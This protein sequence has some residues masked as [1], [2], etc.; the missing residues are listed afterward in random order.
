MA[1][2]CLLK[3]RIIVTTVRKAV[4]L[5][6]GIHAHN[7]AGVAVG[8]TITAVHNGATHVQGTINGY[9]ERTGNADLVVII[10]NLM[11][12]LKKKCIP[13]ASLKRL[14]EFSR[15]VDELANQT[16]NSRQPYVGR[17]SFAHK[18][19]IHVSAM[20]RHQATYE[21]IPPES[22]GNQR[23]VLISELSGISNIRYKGP[24]NAASISIQW[25]VSNAPFLIVS[26]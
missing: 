10:P 16:P 20:Q 19:G 9:G 1:A 4:S 24:K 18:A 11:L 7:D 5:P 13:L 25:R 6:I 21:H 14:T 23:R 2:P 26:R 15:T 12:K 22:V 8:N 3:L 17:C